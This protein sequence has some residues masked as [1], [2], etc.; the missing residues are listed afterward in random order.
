MAVALGLA[1]DDCSDG[2]L[3]GGVNV[4]VRWP[5]AFAELA[6]DLRSK[7]GRPAF[8][9][10][11]GKASGRLMDQLRT[12]VDE[13][14]SLGMRVGAAS[15]SPSVN[16]LIQDIGGP[17]TLLTDIDVL[18]TP[19]LHVD[20]ISQFRRLAHNTALL[21]AWPGRI[22]AGR[23]YYSLP[24]RADHM[25][26]PARDTIVLRPVDTDFPDEVPYTVERYPS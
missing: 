10:T 1:I 26:E 19:A 8:V 14:V 15:Q 4:T 24:G 12:A 21:V 17:S 16:E 18:F 22:A 9:D 11:S 23:L 13:V 7:R 3:R 20:V 5:D 6:R 2:K 25:D